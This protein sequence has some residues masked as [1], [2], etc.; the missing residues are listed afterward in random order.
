MDKLLSKAGTTLVTFAVRSGVQLASSY[1][2]KSVSKLVEGVPEKDRRRVERLKIKLQNRI[3]IITHAIELIRL[4]AARGNT[5]MEGT[6]N[7]A[8]ELKSEIDDFHDYITDLSENESLK[9]EEIVSIE[10]SMNILLLKINQTIP[11]I[12]LALTTSGARL[13]GNMNSFVSPGQLLKS[14][15]IVHDSNEI[16]KTAIRNR[17][18]DEV[19][20]QV[21]PSF[22]M[23]TYDIFYSAPDSGSNQSKAKIIWKER[24]PRSTIRIIRVVNKNFEYS[25]ILGIEENFNDERYH[26]EDDKPEQ[27]KVDTRAIHRV[28]FSASGK[29]LKLE[30]R[31][32]PV[33]VLKVRKVTTEQIDNEI[34]SQ[35]GRTKNNKKA[36]SKFDWLAFGCYDDIDNG[37]ESTKSS[38][39]DEDTDSNNV[40]VNAA[41]VI[42]VKEPIIKKENAVKRNSATYNRKAIIPEIPFVSKSLSLMEYLLRI[43]ALQANDQQSVFDVKDE[44]LRL[45]LNDENTVRSENEETEIDHLESKFKNLTV[46]DKLTMSGSP[47]K[48]LSQIEQNKEAESK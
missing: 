9:K 41:D 36:E 29:L 47:H 19:N 10:K 30:D 18:N 48:T 37:D 31:N 1:V 43:C 39:S 15:A 11:I 40:G 20:I 28:F 24:Y 44:R 12:N 13:S 21:G 22:D 35:T 17:D 4:I 6:I 2:L 23:T 7:L 34:T 16:Y 38:E 5:E 32:S 27:I 14:A 3:D 26:D 42:S 46:N 8:D 25:Y 33:L 45:Y